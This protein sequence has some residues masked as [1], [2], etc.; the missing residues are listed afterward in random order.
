MSISHDWKKRID[1]AAKYKTAKLEVEL[2][3]DVV[4]TIIVAFFIL[5]LVIR[6]G[7]VHSGLPI[8][9]SNTCL[10]YGHDNACL[11]FPH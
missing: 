5:L 10:E 9:S 3:F 8:P 1:N 11:V 6:A 2:A 4:L 7:Y